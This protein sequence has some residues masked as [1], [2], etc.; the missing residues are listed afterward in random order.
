MST[1]RPLNFVWIDKDFSFF[2]ML[3]FPLIDNDSE[4][5]KDTT[6]SSFGLSP[7][8]KRLQCFERALSNYLHIFRCNHFKYQSNLADEKGFVLICQSDV[9]FR[10][11]VEGS[12]VFNKLTLVKIFLPEMNLSGREFDFEFF[13]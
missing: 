11:N 13:A 7:R 9:N 2:E 6:N 1:W 5:K 12:S 8:V 4:V 10:Q 3:L